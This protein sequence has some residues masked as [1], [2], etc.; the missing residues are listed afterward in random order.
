MCCETER[1]LL[2]WG[3]INLSN[4]ALLDFEKH[5]T[6]IERNKSR[7]L[8]LFNKDISLSISS[9]KNNCVSHM[10]RYFLFFYFFI[11]IL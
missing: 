11:T 4:H 7:F 5:M 3:T 8:G 6:Y 10:G 2:K 9:G 1:G